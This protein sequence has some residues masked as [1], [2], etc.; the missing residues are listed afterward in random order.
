MPHTLSVS[1]P[2]LVHRMTGMFFVAS[3]RV[4]VRVAWKP[5]CPGRTTSMSTRSGRDCL[6]FVIASSALSAV[7]TL[8]PFLD[9]RS[10]RNWRSVGESSTTR[11]VLIAIGCLSGRNG[12][13]LDVLGD[14]SD[15]PFLG[16]GLG[17]IA[18][19]AGKPAARAVEDAVFAREHDH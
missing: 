4:R 13:R 1:W 9:R 19:R 3:S 6:T 2:L 5:F 10:V 14:R 16:E 18:I 15:Q 11:I 12:R 8:K 7:A 17:E